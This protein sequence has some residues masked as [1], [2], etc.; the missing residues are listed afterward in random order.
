VI[1]L[2]ADA[3][4]KQRALLHTDAALVLEGLELQ[5]VTQDTKTEED[6]DPVLLATSAP[7]WALNC[8]F[9]SLPNLKGRSWDNRIIADSLFCELRNC[10]IC[11]QGHLQVT[12]LKAGQRVIMDN[13]LQIAGGFGLEAANLEEKRPAVIR[14]TRTTRQDGS[15]GFW[16][17]PDKAPALR[18]ADRPGKLVRVEASGNIFDAASPMRL[19]QMLPDKVLPPDDAQGLLAEFVGWQGQR[20]LY[21]VDGPFLRQTAMDKFHDS[22]KP[23]RNLAEW[24]QFWGSAETNS[25]EGRVKYH[26][27]NLN[28]TMRDRPEKLTPEDFRLRSDSPGYK[29]GKDGQD[30]G[31]D[32]D[33]VGPGPAYE[34]WKKTPEYQQW[35]KDTK[36]AVVR[37]Q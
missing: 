21:A 30:L 1:K 33:L 10:E 19:A 25:L 31:A 15:V 12:R 32:M 5:R 16:F 11:P 28:S 36:Q 24:K 34:R 6:F 3:T 23:I 4:R 2:N 8:R 14:L 13:C 17:F 35:L 9:L 26:G 18:G 37:S 20:N 22:A 7:L 29:A 27:G